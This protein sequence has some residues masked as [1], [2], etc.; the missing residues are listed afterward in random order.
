MKEK[1]NKNKDREEQTGDENYSE[2]MR[3][4]SFVVRLALSIIL[5]ERELYESNMLR[6]SVDV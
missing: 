2:S 5:K 3:T 4:K 6:R 1:G